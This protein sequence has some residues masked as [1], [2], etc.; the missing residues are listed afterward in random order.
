MWNFVKGLTKVHENNI[1]CSVIIHGFGYFL[2]KLNQ[3]TG[4]L[5]AVLALVAH[6]KPLEKVVCRL[7]L[8]QSIWCRKMVDRLWKVMSP[9]LECVWILDNK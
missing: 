6:P 8:L 4:A 3:R 7:E 9:N 1:Y 2:K 5:L